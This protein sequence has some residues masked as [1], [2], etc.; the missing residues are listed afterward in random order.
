L[1]AEPLVFLTGRNHHSNAMACIT[2]ARPIPGSYGRVPLANGFPLR[3]ADAVRL[4]AFAIGKWHLT[5]SEDM[6]L[7]CNRKWWPLGRGFDRFYGFLG[8]ENRSMD[9]VAYLRQS[10]HQAAED[11]G[12]RL[13]QRGRLDGQGEGVHRRLETGGAGTALSSCTSAPAPA[14][15]PTTPRRNGSPSTRA[16]STPGWDDYREKA[17]AKQ[18]K[19]GICRKEPSCRR[20]TGGQPWAILNKDDSGCLPTRWKSMPRTWRLWITT[21]AV[22]QIPGG[23]GPARQHVDYPGVRQ[24][25]V[26]RGR[27]GRIVQ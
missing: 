3:D 4:T 24:W 9:A 11:S 8:G 25:R 27:T 1:L 13:S 15:L 7:G 20:L 2:K 6:N 26:S 19:I 21:S 17:L 5:P 14:T 18:I 16:N 23:D 22:G 12:T 10:L